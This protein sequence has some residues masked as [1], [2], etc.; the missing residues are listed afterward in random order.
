MEMKSKTD[1]AEREATADEL[2]IMVTGER[3]IPGTQHLCW[4]IRNGMELNCSNNCLLNLNE[5]FFHDNT[6]ALFA[7]ARSIK[8]A[9]AETSRELNDFTFYFLC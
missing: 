5:V 2:K 7:Y 8:V 6:M 1:A 3:K 9:S 4:N